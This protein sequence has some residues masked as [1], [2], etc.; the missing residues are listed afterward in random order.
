M[1][2]WRYGQIQCKSVKHI[3]LACGG[4]IRLVGNVPCMHAYVRRTE[5]RF[6]RK[7]LNIVTFASQVHTCID[8]SP[9]TY[10]YA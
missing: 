9:A 5:L 6:Y 7:V 2:V 1:C 4:R 8:V 10:T 3:Q